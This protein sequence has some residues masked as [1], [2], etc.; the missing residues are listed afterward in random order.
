MSN[1]TPPTSTALW[2][3]IGLVLSLAINTFFIGLA[4]GGKLTSDRWTDGMRDRLGLEA[5]PRGGPHQG[6]PPDLDPRALTRMLPE[7]AREEIRG[8]L[9]ERGPEIR[10]LFENSMRTRAM[11]FDAMRAEPFDQAALVE[12]FAASR[13][14]DS[15]ANQ[16]IHDLTVEIVAGLTN[17]ERAQIGTDLGQRFPDM[18]ERRDR[19][20]R[21]RDQRR[22]PPDDT[23]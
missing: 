22:P 16:A 13:Q 5:G 9:A 17:E 19:R 4:V 2:L 12:A 1:P 10:D 14:A 7:S 11:A 21:R 18:H 20:E 8:L 6:M 15:T 23:D 3:G